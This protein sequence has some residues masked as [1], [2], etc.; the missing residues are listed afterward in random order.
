MSAIGL[1]TKLQGGRYT[2]VLDSGETVFCPARGLFRLQ[3][4]SPMAG[5]RVEVGEGRIEQVLPRKNEFVRPAVANVDRLVLM[6]AVV[7]PSPDVG[8]L[9]RMLLYAHTQDCMVN[10]V[11]NKC[12]LPGTTETV[13]KL[14]KAYAAFQPLFISL[15]DKH[16]F[17]LPASDLAVVCGPSGVGKSTLIN[18]ITDAEMETGGLA[19]KTDRGKHTTRH[20]ELLPI[21]QGIR[22]GYIADTPGFSL[23]DTP[24]IPPEDLAGCYPE[25]APLLGCC[26]FDNCLHDAEPGCAVKNGDVPPG[27]YRRY[28]EILKEIRE[29]EQY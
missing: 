25:F 4:V 16:D 29:N 5:D 26:R 28:L 2:V 21:K 7:S 24:C 13:D 17:Q 15:L 8:L 9:D 6:F 18:A 27:R 10:I 20:V 22:Q 14:Q 12:D 19:A 23:L 11:F 3:G 1:V